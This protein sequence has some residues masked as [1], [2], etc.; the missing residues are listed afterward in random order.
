[1]AFPSEWAIYGIFRCPFVVPFISC[2]NCPVMTSPGRAAG[3]FR[4]FWGGLICL[5]V[6]F[7]RAFCGWVCPGG[8]TN[9]LLSKFPVRPKL[10]KSASEWLPYGKYAALVFAIWAYFILNQPRVN[11][12]IRIGEFW[13]AMAPTFEL[14][15]PL[16]VFRTCAV[17]LLL[18]AGLFAGM[19]WCRF[20]CPT[21]A[22]L[23]FARRF[24]FFRVWKDSSCTNCDIC[25]KACCMDTR[26]GETNCTNCCVCVS[27]CPHDRIHVGREKA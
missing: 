7:G 16:W 24:S 9:R 13:S 11:V 27:L 8:L 18:A 14:A 21:R 1:M 19:L 20:E 22:V 23:E 25:R 26:P 10:P 6:L 12:P 2:Q 3:F 5:A 15:F 4:G 17:V